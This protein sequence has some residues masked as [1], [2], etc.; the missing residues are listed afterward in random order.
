VT[1]ENSIIGAVAVQ[2]KVKGVLSSEARE[3]GTETLTFE[4]DTIPGA[5]WQLE[6]QALLPPGLRV[7]L[8]ERGGR[9]CALVTS[10]RGDTE[11]AV[12]AFERAVSGANQVS[13]EAHLVAANDRRARER[14][15][16]GE[17]S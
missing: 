7:S 15:L 6:L 13:H 1:D 11:Q 8:F 4:L 12:A 9:K 5:V 10:T 17:R 2:A 3:D 16:A 14:A